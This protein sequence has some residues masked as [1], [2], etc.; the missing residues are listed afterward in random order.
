MSGA[1]R[2]VPSRL[3][4]LQGFYFARSRAL[5]STWAEDQVRAHAEAWGPERVGRVLLSA[6]DQ[7]KAWTHSR[8]RYSVEGV[9][10][11]LDRYSHALPTLQ[12]E[13]M[14]QLDAI[15]GRG[16]DAAPRTSGDKGSKASATAAEAN[17]GPD[18]SVDRAE[19]GARLV[20]HTGF[21]VK[22]LHASQPRTPST[23]KRHMRRKKQDR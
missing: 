12:A 5:G 6:S 14:A 21:P 19:I 13:A 10:I 18:P 22:R 20:P 11:T 4:P 1:R 23:T 3:E 7:A 9:A 8:P 15:P 2:E 16:A 17:E